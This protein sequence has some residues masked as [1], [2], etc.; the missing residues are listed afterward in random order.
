MKTIPEIDICGICTDPECDGIACVQHLHADDED[1]QVVIERLQLLVR[2][3]A[4]FIAGCEL[5]RSAG[6]GSLPRIEEQ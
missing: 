4:A 3:G 1:D 2:A 6:Y 5:M